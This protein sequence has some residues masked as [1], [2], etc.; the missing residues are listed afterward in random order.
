MPR[1][2]T[3]LSAGSK[4]ASA[5]DVGRVCCSGTRQTANGAART[6]LACTNPAW[7]AACAHDPNEKVVEKGL[8]CSG[9][10][11]T[12]RDEGVI[13]SVGESGC[14]GVCSAWGRLDA[15]MA[16]GCD[17]ALMAG[18]RLDGGGNGGA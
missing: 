8:G 4:T 12:L 13:W 6:L 14:E 10:G 2:A 16:S 18:T 3:T 11:A 7:D 17:G 1:A 5:P 9:D 15:R